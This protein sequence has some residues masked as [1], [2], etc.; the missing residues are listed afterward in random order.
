[1]KVIEVLLKEK[2]TFSCDVLLIE[3]N[4]LPSAVVKKINKQRFL[5]V[6]Q[7]SLAKLKKIYFVKSLKLGILIKRKKI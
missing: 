7:I 1:M 3:R 6:Y 2:S 4:R 5:N